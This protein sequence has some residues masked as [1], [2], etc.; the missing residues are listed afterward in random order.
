MPVVTVIAAA[1]V[2]I[3]ACVCATMAGASSA[4]FPPPGRI[5]YSDSM[6][7]RDPRGYGLFLFTA[8]TGG[9]GARQHPCVRSIYGS[10]VA[11]RGLSR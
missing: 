7:V 5:V 10:A 3:T 6:P 4:S 9:T 1:Y 8:A 11:G 2:L